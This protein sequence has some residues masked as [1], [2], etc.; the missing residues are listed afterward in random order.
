MND[1]DY[2]QAEVYISQMEAGESLNPWHVKQ[3]APLMRELLERAK[4]TEKAL[5]VVR[6]GLSLIADELGPLAEGLK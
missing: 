1:F 3:M 5:G 4:R 2:E 6:D